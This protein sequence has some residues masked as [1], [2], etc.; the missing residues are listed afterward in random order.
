MTAL[1]VCAVLTVLLSGV[2]CAL[3]LWLRRSFGSYTERIERANQL[4]RQS[5]ESTRRVIDLARDDL[6]DIERLRREIL[7]TLKRD[8]PSPPTERSA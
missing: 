7:E 3:L 1:D 5:N 4:T 2:A 8:T 6:N